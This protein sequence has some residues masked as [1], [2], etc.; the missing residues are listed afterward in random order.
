MRDLTRWDQIRLVATR[1]V[2]ERGGSRSFKVSTAVSV[3]IVVA[4]IVVPTFFSDDGPTEWELG[5][6]GD[7]PA[8][9]EATLELAVASQGAELTIVRLPDD[10]DAEE[11]S[12]DGD[13]DAVLRGRELV[14]EE[15]PPGGLAAAVNLALSQSS[16][17]EQLADAG[18]EPDEAAEAIDIEPVEVRTTESSEED[19][20]AEAAAFIGVVA[21]FIAINSYGAW[22]LTGVLEEKAS[23]VVEL[24]VAAMPARALLAGK[25]LGIGV[26]GIA[27]LLI[28]GAAGVVAALAVDLTDVPASLI[29]ALA[30]IL[31]WFVLGFALYAVGYA[32]AGSLVSRQ[33]DAQS[34]AGPMAY[35]ILS[36]YFLTLGVV[37]PNPESTAARILS[38][39]P[40]L[41]PMAMPSRIAQDAAAGWEI[42]LSVVIMLVSIWLMVRLAGRIYE[43]SLL[44]TGARIKLRTALRDARAAGRATVP[45]AG[46]R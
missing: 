22:V 30:S 46:T 13:V 27:Q 10:A 14:S 16:L 34:A 35:V 24:I 18:L 36:A 7:T 17:L 20:T 41:A 43:Q 40:P 33:E 2:K 38:Q 44:R 8:G 6:I 39:L 9:F 19:G 37:A 3:V 4:L 5:L 11:A 21:L 26:L 29:P 42:A 12:A 15:E 45:D 28:I 31:V 25:V 1:E 23:R 32:A